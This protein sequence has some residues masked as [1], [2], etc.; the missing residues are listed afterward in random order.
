MAIFVTWEVP[1]TRCVSR[2]LVIVCQLT[3]SSQTIF[4]FNKFYLDYDINSV[5]QELHHEPP[6]HTP[7]E[8]EFALESKYDGSSNL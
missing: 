8:G 6:F 7:I 3:D 2:S 1:K 5:L 4:V